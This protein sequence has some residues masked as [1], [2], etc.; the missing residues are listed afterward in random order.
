MSL[1]FRRPSTLSEIKGSVT[2]I[3]TFVTDNEITS[4]LDL[5]KVLVQLSPD[6]PADMLDKTVLHVVQVNSSY[7]SK[8]A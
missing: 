3:Q 7:L 6:S 4:T 2:W 8:L 1:V 5:I